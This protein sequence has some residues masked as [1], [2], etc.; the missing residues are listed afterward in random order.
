MRILDS[1]IVGTWSQYFQKLIPY[2]RF[3]KDFGYPDT[4]LGYPISKNLVSSPDCA[5]VEEGGNGG[6]QW[7]GSRGRRRCSAESTVL[8]RQG[9]TTV[10]DGSRERLGKSLAEREEAAHVLFGVHTCGDGSPTTSENTT[11]YCTNDIVLPLFR[12]TYF[13][14]LT[15][16]TLMI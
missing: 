6:Q 5:V 10:V 11:T 3:D 14:F 12:S 15:I 7:L 8:R 16:I 13:S 2:N 1:K 4:R 9:G